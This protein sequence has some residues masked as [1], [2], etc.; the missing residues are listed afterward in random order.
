MVSSWQHQAGICMLYPLTA[1]ATLGMVG[2]YVW[3]M[4]LIGPA[5]R[6]HGVKAPDT[7]GPDDFNRVYRAHVNTLEQLVMM[8][9]VLWVFALAVGDRWAALLGLVWIMGRIV[10]VLGYTAAANKRGTGFMIG[11]AALAIGLFGSAGTI[12]WDVLR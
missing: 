12:L 8:L 7:T 10:Y 11:L 9:P 5:R 2:V 1:L 3:T 6:K 4:V